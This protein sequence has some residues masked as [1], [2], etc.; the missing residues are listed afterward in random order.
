MT[1]PASAPHALERIFERFYTDR[2]HEGFGQNS[3][4]GL[5]ISRQ[6]IEA[7]RGTIRAENRL[8]RR[9]PMASDRGW[10]RASSSPAGRCRR[11]MST[12]RQPSMPATCGRAK[13]AC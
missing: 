4:L 12:T 8:G 9:E 3:G 10:A 11:R 13:P 7:H 2:P 1:G 5:S 6:I